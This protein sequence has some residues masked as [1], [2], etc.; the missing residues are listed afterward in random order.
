MVCLTFY[1]LSV[2][3]DKLSGTIKENG[4]LVRVTVNNAAYLTDD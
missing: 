2:S 4:S 3:I 1:N